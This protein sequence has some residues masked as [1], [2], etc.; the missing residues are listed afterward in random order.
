MFPIRQILVSTPGESNPK[1]P[2]LYRRMTVKQAQILSTT[3]DNFKRA[4][5]LS[6][7]NPERSEG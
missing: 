3:K 5:Q 7:F 6:T 4:A 2:N 1:P